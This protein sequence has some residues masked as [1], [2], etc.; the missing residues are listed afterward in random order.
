MIVPVE[1]LKTDTFPVVDCRLV[2]V[3]VVDCRVVM[4]P[5][6][7]CK[8]IKDPVEVLSVDIFPIVAC[9]VEALKTE[10]FKF[11]ANAFDTKV[12]THDVVGIVE[13]LS[14]LDKKGVIIG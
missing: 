7:A 13:E 3:P 5:E 10:V 4:V 9:M 1:A 14:E 12:F 6:V 8:L 2:I 11:V